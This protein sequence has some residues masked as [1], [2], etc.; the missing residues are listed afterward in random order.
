VLVNKEERLVLVKGM[1]YPEIKIDNVFFENS[2]LNFKIS[3]YLRRELEG[4]QVGFLKVTVLIPGVEGESIF[5]ET[6]FLQVSED[7]MSVSIPFK[8]LMKGNFNVFIIANDLLTERK[9][10]VVRPLKL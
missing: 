6:K 5:G 10:K 9:A 7:V 4:K 2:F 1:P 3:G 8:Q